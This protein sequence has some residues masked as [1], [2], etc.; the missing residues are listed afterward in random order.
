MTESL[1]AHGIDSLVDLIE[2]ISKLTESLAAHGIHSLVDR[3][4]RILK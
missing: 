4:E 2:R 1:A 3:I